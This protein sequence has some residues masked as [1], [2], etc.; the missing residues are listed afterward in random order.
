LYPTFVYIEDRFGVKASRLALFGFGALEDAA[1][2]QFEAELEIPVEAVRSPMAAISGHN[3]GLL[4]Y[5]A[6]AR[7][8]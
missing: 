1:V 8:A 6:G 2:R 7:A 5:L 3:V 4:G